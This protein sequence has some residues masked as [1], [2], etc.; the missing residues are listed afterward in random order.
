MQNEQYTPIDSPF[1]S[2]KREDWKKLNGHFTHTFAQQDLDQLH[3][4][5]EPL[6]A[7]EI[8]DVYFPLSHL[9]G[10]HIER[11]H[12]LHKRSNLFFQKNESRLPFIIGIAGSVAVGKSTTARVLQRVLALLPTKPKVD[13]VTTDGFLYPNKELNEKGIMNRKGFPESYDAKKLIQFLSAIKSGVGSVSVPVYSHLAYDVLPDDQQQIIDHPDIL[14]VE[15]IN[16]LQV[17]SQRAKKGHNSVFVSDFFDYSIYVHA[18]EKNLL[19]WY[20][21]RF[22]S[23]RNT[24]FQDPASFFHRYANMNTKESVQMAHQI[25]NEINKPNLEHNILPTRYRADLILEKGSH[26]FVKNIKVRKI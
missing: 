22:E 16:V 13:L 4:L 8:E 12:D 20:T 19:E 3:A 25:W 21:N 10:I 7:E 2:I 11:F 17:N 24:A 23:L 15:G 6:N 26:H 9:L 5:N 14:I 18:S 1:T